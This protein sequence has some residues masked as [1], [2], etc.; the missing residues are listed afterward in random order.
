MH[1]A[2][3]HEVSVGFLAVLAET[4]TVIACDDDRRRGEPSGSFERVEQASV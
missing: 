3:V 2:P 4:L 1:R